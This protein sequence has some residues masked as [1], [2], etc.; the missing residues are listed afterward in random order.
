MSSHARSITRT[1]QG[2][3]VSRSSSEAQSRRTP[4]YARIA[5]DIREAIKIGALGPDDLVSSASALCERYGVSMITA[6]SALNLL[7]TEGLVYGVAGKGTFV[8]PQRRMI[9]TAPH[10]YFQRTERT[11]VHEAERAGMRPD[12]EHATATI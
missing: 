2:G 8:A 10:R 9:R 7:R 1:A 11:Y 6:K 4:E 12:V 3:P 5:S